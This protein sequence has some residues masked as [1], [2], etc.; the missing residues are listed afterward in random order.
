MAY[1]NPAPPPMQHVYAPPP[2]SSYDYSDMF[3]ATPSN[4]TTFHPGGVW[5]MDSGATLKPN[6]TK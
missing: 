2:A 1:T 3:N 6:S 5:V 4:S